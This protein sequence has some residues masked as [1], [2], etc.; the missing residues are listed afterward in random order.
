MR[1]ERQPQR[2]EDNACKVMRADIDRVE[3]QRQGHF[4]HG[5]IELALRFERMSVP[6]MRIARTRIQFDASLQLCLGAGSITNWA[7]ALPR[8]LDLLAIARR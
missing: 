2:H 4:L 5:F 3:I 7:N 6:M 1:E 8:E